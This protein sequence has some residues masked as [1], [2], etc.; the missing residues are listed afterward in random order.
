MGSTPPDGG[1]GRGLFQIDYDWHEFA[2]TGNW[3][4][5]K[6][7]ILY[8]CHVLADSRDQLARQTNLQGE[9]LLKAALAGYNAGWPTVLQA[10]QAGDDPDTVTTHRSYARTV[11]NKAGWFQRRGW[12]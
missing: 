7:N 3:H 9:A 12:I 5:P 4:D 1:F 11:L 6:A 2:R 10:V 8:G